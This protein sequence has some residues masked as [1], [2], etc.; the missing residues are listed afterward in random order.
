M[1]VSALASGGGDYDYKSLGAD[2]GT[3]KPEYALC[4]A[5]QEQSPIDLKPGETSSSDIMRLIGFDYFDFPVQPA[6][7]TGSDN[8]SQT[9]NLPADTDDLAEDTLRS[10]LEITFPNSGDGT[11]EF[12][13]LQFHFHSPSEHTVDGKYYDLEMH[14]V[15]HY[16]GKTGDEE[17]YLGA[18]I[19]VFFDTTEGGTDENEFLQTVFKAIDSRNEVDPSQLNLMEFLR[20]VNFGNYFSYNGSLTTPPCTEGIKWNVV[21]PVLSIS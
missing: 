6:F 2:W 5:G 10:K 12:T 7:S 13:P 17:G 19:G 16:R 3:I 8:A 15:H 4:D 11:A 21:K 14:I 9:I 1:A 18:V 20:T